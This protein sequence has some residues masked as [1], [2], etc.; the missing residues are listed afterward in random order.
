MT[1][2]NFILVLNTCPTNEA[3]NIAKDIIKKKIAACVNITPKI[4]SI[5]FWSNT[6]NEET[7]SQLIIKTKITC[8]KKIEKYL[9]KTIS[10]DNP[11]II[12]LPIIYG[13]NNYLKWIN[14]IIE[15]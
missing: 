3:N 7:E 4:N 1:E 9:L 6:I 5:Y 13:S 10:Y 14:D 12:A 8:L 15:T 11:E 2:T